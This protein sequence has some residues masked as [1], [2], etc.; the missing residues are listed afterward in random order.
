MYGNLELALNNVS[1][2]STVVYISFS[3]GVFS[4]TETDSSCFLEVNNL[5][6]RALLIA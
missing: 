5:C 6:G 3:S 1:W 4:G 2:D